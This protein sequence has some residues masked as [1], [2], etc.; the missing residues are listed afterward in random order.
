MKYICLKVKYLLVVVDSC[1]VIF[2]VSMSKWSF[3]CNIKFL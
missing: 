3:Y 2:S 1:R